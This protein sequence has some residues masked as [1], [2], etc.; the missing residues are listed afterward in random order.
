MPGGPSL[1]GDT[2]RVCDQK[3]PGSSPVLV[4]L[5]WTNT[6]TSASGE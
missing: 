1:G 3:V 4:A 5:V 2:H 6:F